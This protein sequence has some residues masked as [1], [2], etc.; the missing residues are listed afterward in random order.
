MAVRC[1]CHLGS[2]PVPYAQ[3][4][5]RHSSV[6]VSNARYLRTCCTAKH[7]EWFRSRQLAVRPCDST[8]CLQPTQ[9]KLC[10]FWLGALIAALEG[11]TA[12]KH[13]EL[14]TLV[15]TTYIFAFT[16]AAIPSAMQRPLVRGAVNLVRLAKGGT[17]SS[18]AAKSTHGQA[19][20]NANLLLL[21]QILHDAVLSALPESQE[22]QKH[23]FFAKLNPAAA[24]R[25]P[26]QML[27]RLQDA[28]AR[29]HFRLQEGLEH[30]VRHMSG[31]AAQITQSPPHGTD[32]QLDLVLCVKGL[33]LC[34]SPWARRAPSLDC[35]EVGRASC[36]ASRPEGALTTSFGSCSMLIQIASAHGRSGAQRPP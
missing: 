26:A 32:C 27:L 36:L 28:T 14:P 35:H 29:A 24:M 9:P 30:L 21:R 5:R 31:H 17:Y 8:L 16:G 4:M 11:A 15:L 6:N 33:G 25:A 13:A 23:S 12:R 20:Q 34:G 18:E 1:C 22:L 10:S 2:W 7:L 19:R 3:R